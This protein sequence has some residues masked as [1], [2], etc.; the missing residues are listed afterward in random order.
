MESKYSSKLS[1]IVLVFLAYASIA[2]ANEGAFY[3]SVG[4][5]RAEYDLGSGFDESDTGLFV[6]NLGYKVNRYFAVELGYQDFGDISVSGNGSA[7]VEA[8]AF[9]AAIVGRL[10]FSNQFSAFA[11]LGV[12][13]WDGE[14]SF[15]NVPGF[16]SGNASDDGSDIYYGVGGELVLQNGLAVFIEYQF[17]DLDDLEIDTFGGSIKYYFPTNF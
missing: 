14:V 17:H 13:F 5:S 6:V 4:L 9:Q 10:P 16:G 11:E 8:D 1:L 12:D 3:G 15:Q 2:T 7:D